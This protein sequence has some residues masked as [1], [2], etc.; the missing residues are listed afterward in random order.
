MTFGAT[1]FLSAG[2]DDIFSKNGDTS[3]LHGRGYLFLRRRPASSL[4]DQGADLLT[5]GWAM[6]WALKADHSGHRLLPRSRARP[7]RQATVP[8]P[9]APGPVHAGPRCSPLCSPQAPCW[10]NLTVNQTTLALREGLQESSQ[11][12]LEDLPPQ[13]AGQMVDGGGPVCSR[14]TP[15]GSSTD[16]ARPPEKADLAGGGLHRGYAAW[17]KRCSGRWPK[18]W[19]AAAPARCWWPGRRLAAPFRICHRR[20]HL[21]WFIVKAGHTPGPPSGRGMIWGDA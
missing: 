21:K 17:R 18:S 13:K 12:E 15:P 7:G 19:C 20:N 1:F 3:I 16:L 8:G 10:T 6:S 4:L 2:V 11:K 9:G 5:I 14:A